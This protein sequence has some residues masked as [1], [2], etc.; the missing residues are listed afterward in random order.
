MEL[1]RLTKKTQRAH[2]AAAPAM[3]AAAD[4]MADGAVAVMT[5][6]AAAAIVVAVAAVVTGA[7]ADDSPPTCFEIM[8][9][10][11]RLGMFPSRFFC[12]FSGGMNRAVKFCLF[13]IEN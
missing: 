6:V 2:N 4:A 11:G 9:N 10:T 3:A 7:A 12:G 1:C 13:Y 8:R 5:V